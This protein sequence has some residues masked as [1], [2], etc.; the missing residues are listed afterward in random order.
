MQRLSKNDILGRLRALRRPGLSELAFVVVGLA[1]L[2]LPQWWA[3]SRNKSQRRQEVHV[4]LRTT[5]ETTSAMIEAW[6]AEQMRQAT[7]LS[8]SSRF[9]DL[10][11]EAD[12]GSG[13]ALN[14][15][16]RLAQSEGFDE[17]V[18]LPP[19]QESSLRT[20]GP[21]ERSLPVDPETMRVTAGW[22][23]WEETPRWRTAAIVPLDPDGQ[24]DAIVAFP[25]DAGS[26][27][28]EILDQRA[29]GRSG[30][31][32]AFELGGS[33]LADS[34]GQAAAPC[35]QSA[36]TV[37]MRAGEGDDSG[38]LS[39]LEGYHN[40]RGETVIGVWTL[41]SELGVGLITEISLDEA[42]SAAATSQLTFVGLGVLLGGVLLMLVLLQTSGES[43]SESEP[44]QPSRSNAAWGILGVALLATV[45]A[46]ATARSRYVEFQ[47]DRFLSAAQR[48][49]T[50]LLHRL[51][52]QATA[53]RAIRG[54]AETLPYMDRERQV[55][56]LGAMDLKTEF[57]AIACLQWMRLDAEQVSRAGAPFCIDDQD[58]A[59]CSACSDPASS[60][61]FAQ[62]VRLADEREAIAVSFEVGKQMRNR[63]LIAM[64]PAPAT[65]H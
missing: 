37:L 5:V 21:A 15:L 26:K 8:N 50:E 4:A 3:L 47:R 34:A 55:R 44:K 46:W 49:E 23:T 22:I 6:A 11:E 64:A 16:N 13:D 38:T 40:C 43:I 56:F 31:T 61:S 36:A 27:L 42:Y 65:R 51:E 60:A 1:C 58:R 14:E 10:V 2:L 33:W 59:S 28:K 30:R 12:A 17:A 62:A 7:R 9:S 41:D 52:H 39:N 48:V 54:A 29:L 19:L 32:T 45:I 20:H 57:S 63:A 35:D 18:V 25:I 53:L 24:S